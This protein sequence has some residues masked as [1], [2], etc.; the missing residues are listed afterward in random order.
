MILYKFGTTLLFISLIESILAHNRSFLYVFKNG[1]NSDTKYNF[2]I[3]I[4]V[5][6]PFFV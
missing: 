1:K 3:L 5:Q 4:L 6:S 2:E